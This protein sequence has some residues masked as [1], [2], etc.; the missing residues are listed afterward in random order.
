VEEVEEYIRRFALK[1]AHYTLLFETED[2]EPAGVSAF[3]RVDIRIGRRRRA[4][5]WHLEVIALTP[6]WRGKDV[7]ADID[8]CSSRMRASEYLLRATFRRML[9]I[10]PRRAIVVARV[11][12]DN[13]ISMAVCAR[14][15]LDRTERETDEYWGMIG[16][17]DPAAGPT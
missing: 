4:P 9:E 14:V 2:G 12:D 15:G 7:D 17:V 16:E 6:A 8:G 11:H 5:G 1:T 10:D 3:S 13:R